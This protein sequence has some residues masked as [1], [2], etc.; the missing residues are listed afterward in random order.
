MNTTAIVPDHELAAA[1]PAY[2]GWVATYE[3]PGFVH[4]SHPDGDYAVNVSSD[5][6]GDACLDIQISTADLAR[7]INDGENAPWPHEGRTAEKMFARIHPYLDKYQ[8]TP[9]HTSKES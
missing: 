9:A 6:N 7:S 3:Y 5:F 4:Y 1:L 8:P 2:N